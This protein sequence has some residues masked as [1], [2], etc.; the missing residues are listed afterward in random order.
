MSAGWLTQYYGGAQSGG[1]PSGG[2]KQTAEQAY[3]NAIKYWTERKRA[4]GVTY[5]P[6]PMKAPKIKQAN[7]KEFSRAWLVKKAKLY[8]LKYSGE[9]VSQLS[10]RLS[11]YLLTSDAA[12]VPKYGPKP[13]ANDWYKRAKIAH[14][15]AQLAEQAERNTDVRNDY[16]R[17][18]RRGDDAAP[19]VADAGRRA[20]HRDRLF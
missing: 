5:V 2:A 8:G 6:K 17:A 3:Q 20:G 19:V 16:A 18:G 7:P 9:T 13:T 14:E 11:P 12:Y 15:N 10:M 4:Q 1:A